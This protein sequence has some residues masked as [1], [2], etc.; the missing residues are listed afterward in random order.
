M[1]YSGVS[2]LIFSFR[3][4]TTTLLTWLVSSTQSMAWQNGAYGPYYPQPVFY[5]Q[6]NPYT[7]PAYYRSYNQ[8]YYYAPRS[9]YAPAKARLKN[10]INRNQDYQT[11][12]GDK[13]KAKVETQTQHINSKKQAFID[14]LLPYIQKEN[15]RLKQ[16]QQRISNIILALDSGFG[17]PQKSQTI[18]QQLAKKYRVQGNALMNPDA[19]AELLKKIDIIPAS[20]TLAQAANESAWGKSR[21]ATEANNLFGIW[22]YDESKGLKPLHREAEKKHLVRKFENPGESVQYYM[23]MLNSHPAYKKL[24]DIRHQARQ[25]N[26]TPDGLA[27][28]A[29]LEKYSA[30]GKQYI[31]L[32][33]Q[34]IRQ[35]KWALLDTKKQSV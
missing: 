24:R 8:G 27:M 34:L 18:I 15:A 4:I 16:L 3:L 9:A 12:S 21:F 22:T 2:R 1:S 33:Q 23:L 7:Q 20:L 29:G 14:T 17:I 32:I 35:N 13:K 28:A 10:T 19:R 11:P 26:K 31:Y 6:F 5:N 30:R 25:K